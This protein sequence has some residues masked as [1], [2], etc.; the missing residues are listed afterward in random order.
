MAFDWASITGNKKFMQFGGEAL[1]DLGY[2]LSRG[3]DFGDALG[4]ATMRSQEMQPQRDYASQQKA[5]EAKRQ[6]TINQTAMFLREKGAEDLAAAVEGGMT[7]GADAFNQWYAG[8][9]PKAPTADWAKLNDGTLFNQRTGETMPLEGMEGG[10]VDPAEAFNREKDLAAQYAGQD[11]VKTYQAVRNSYERVRQSAEI[12]NTNPDG[13][14]AADI[15]LVFA[16]M[17]MLDPT[18]VV[19][20]GEFAQAAQA[21]GVPSAVLNMYNNLVKGD[22]LTPEVR[23]QFVQ[24]S[25]AIY[26]E[27]TQNL[28]SLN[29]QYSTRASGWGVDPGNFVYAPEKYEPLSGGAPR[30]TSTGVTWSY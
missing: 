15:S 9:Q 4:E 2:G 1:Q 26:N 3:T 27:V 14:G 20:E 23:Q 22:K 13:S 8:Q 19:R 18:S 29:Q 28:E 10:F 30:T 16:Y 25:D 17:K 21:G 6:E 11:P 24:Q 12:G 7:T 5:E